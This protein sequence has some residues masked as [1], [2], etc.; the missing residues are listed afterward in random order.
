MTFKRRVLSVL[1]KADLL[2]LGRGLEL[3][4]KAAMTVAQ[5]REMLAGSKRAKLGVIVTA[6]LGRDKLKAMCEA[7]GLDPTGTEKQA[8]IDR[9]V[10]GSAGR[11]ADREDDREDDET[12]RALGLTDLLIL[13]AVRRE[14]P[15]PKRVAESVPALIDLGLIERAGQGRLMLSRKYHREMG[16][17]GA[18]TRKKGLDRETNKAL[19][20]RH[21]RE[22]PGAQV[23]ELCGVLPSLSRPQVRFLLR[24]LKDAREIHSLGTTRSARWYIG[25]SLQ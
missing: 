19:L 1:G 21:I 16:T 8:L 9:I 24:Q 10:A 4:V 2:E 13:N 12:S 6:D 11:G 22:N 25:P 3:E 7:C 15:V 5:L 18:Y 20:V 14:Q 17:P 23:M